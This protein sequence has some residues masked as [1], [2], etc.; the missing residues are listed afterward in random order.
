M[1]RADQL[2]RALGVCEAGKG[3]FVECL[4]ERLANAAGCEQIMTIDQHA[5]RHAGMALLR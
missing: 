1:D 3:K 2:L 5:A 4:I